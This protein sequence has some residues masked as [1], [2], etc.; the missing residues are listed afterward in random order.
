MIGVVMERQFGFDRDRSDSPQVYD[1]VKKRT[2][3]KNV[4]VRSSF[5]KCLVLDET[6]TFKLYQEMKKFFGE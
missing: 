4:I 3:T 6:T 2:K 1:N 5:Y